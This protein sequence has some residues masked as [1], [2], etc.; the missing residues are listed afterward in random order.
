MFQKTISISGL[1]FFCPSFPPMTFFFLLIRAKVD[2]TRWQ[3]LL[4]HLPCINS[5]APTRVSLFLL[6]VCIAMSVELQSLI[7]FFLLFPPFVLFQLV[8]KSVERRRRN[9]FAHGG[10]RTADTPRRLRLGPG[11]RR[12]GPSVVSDFRVGGLLLRPGTGLYRKWLQS[13]ASFFFFGEP[14]LVPF[15]FTCWRLK[16]AGREREKAFIGIPRRCPCSLG[17][18]G[19]SSSPAPCSYTGG[20]SSFPFPGILVD[21]LLCLS[22]VLEQ[23]AACFHSVNFLFRAIWS[24]SMFSSLHFYF[25]FIFYLSN[26]F[27]ST[28]SSSGV[29]AHVWEPLHLTFLPPSHLHPD[30]QEAENVLT[31]LELSRSIPRTSA[32]ETQPR[33]IITL[34]LCYV[35]NRFR[36]SQERKKFKRGAF[37]NFHTLNHS[38][39]LPWATDNLNN[40]QVH[41]Q[42]T[43]TTIHR[44]SILLLRP[45]LRQFWTKFLL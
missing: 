32:Q 29:R 20:S 10:R 40:T 17:R 30:E 11:R 26:R 24:P 9:L 13:S 43:D 8:Q 16:L 5:L 34:G 42:Y 35:V 6:L 21:S 1:F 23:T 12:R 27:P 15:T 4:T 14:I 22:W 38:S 37:Q 18:R 25:S 39:L 33:C 28:C 7:H 19:S 3:I 45:I 44:L 41:R 2:V 36:K 31:S